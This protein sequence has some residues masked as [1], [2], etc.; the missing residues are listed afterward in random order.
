MN[1]H[2]RSTCGKGFLLAA[3][4]LPPAACQFMSG[5][6]YNS[7]RDPASDYVET[8]AR[9]KRESKRI[10]IEVGRQDCPWTKKLDALF[11]DDK[12]ISGILADRYVIQRVYFGNGNFN[13]RFLSSFPPVRGVPHLFV[14]D[15]DN[16]LL[17]SQET[18]PL[19]S[20]DH[21]DRN[22]VLAFLKKWAAA[23]ALP[24]D[25]GENGAS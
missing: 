2:H 12:D 11:A 16:R 1:S 7:R 25:L 14:I 20:G 6:E 22:L 17:V 3:L 4:F 21:H 8:Q 9:A 5:G 13:A 23:P 19:E 24:P 15:G 10:L 18:D